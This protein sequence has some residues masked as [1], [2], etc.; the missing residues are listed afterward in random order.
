MVNR[1]NSRILK[2]SLIF[3][4]IPNV[5]S[6]FTGKEGTQSLPPRS[7]RRD[8]SRIKYLPQLPFAS[9]NKKNAICLRNSKNK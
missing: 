6:V 4:A 2:T 3:L 9:K 1:D 5:W 8:I 7:N